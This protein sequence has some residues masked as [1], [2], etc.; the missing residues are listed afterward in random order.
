MT[1]RCLPLLRAVRAGCFVNWGKG[2]DDT[3]GKASRD[4]VDS[5]RPFDVTATFAADGSYSIDVTQGGRTRRFFDARSAGNPSGRGISSA[6]VD[7]TR[8]AL[9]RGVVLVYSLWSAPGDEGLAWLDG[10][11]DE[12]EYRHCVLNQTSAVFSNVRLD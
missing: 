5:T 8:D 10:G 2:S 11:C 3:Y 1:P 6:D 9:A 4:G 7:R 12:G